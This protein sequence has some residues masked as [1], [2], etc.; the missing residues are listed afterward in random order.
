MILS[1]STVITI[2]CERISQDTEVLTT[3]HT[4]RQREHWGS[5]EIEMVGK[6]KKRLDLVRVLVLSLA[7]LFVLFAAQGLSHSHP[8]GRADAACQVCQAVHIGS[9]P[10]TV[11]SLLFSPLV[12]TGYV[13]PFIVT[14]HQEL[15]FHDS[16][17]RAP[18]TA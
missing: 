4:R 6:H 11:T 1:R 3:K 18:P 10:K 14:I 9:A 8:S 17:S 7:V 12:A 15:F 5:L 16:P 13:Q 2:S